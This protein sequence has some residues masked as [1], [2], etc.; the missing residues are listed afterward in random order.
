MG[1]KIFLFSYLFIYFMELDGQLGINST[2]SKIFTP[3]VITNDPE[4]V[5]IHCGGWY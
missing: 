5:S 1:K 3:S 2:E 4:I